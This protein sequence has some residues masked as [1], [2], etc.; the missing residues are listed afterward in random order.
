[1]SEEQMRVIRELRHE[2]YAVTIWTPEELGEADPSRVQDRLSE[3]GHEV[4][5]D[6]NN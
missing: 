1:M 3:L 2:G 5:E 6:L 4:I